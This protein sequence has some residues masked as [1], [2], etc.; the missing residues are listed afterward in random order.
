MTYWN[1]KLLVRGIGVKRII[2]KKILC[3]ILF[4]ILSFSCKA[5]NKVSNTESKFINENNEEISIESLID[6]KDWES[7]KKIIE[8]G[9]TN[10]YIY[11]TVPLLSYFVSNNLT[12]M[13]KLLISRGVDIQKID[14]QL[15]V[16]MFETVI[17][18][19]NTELERLFLQNGIDLNYRND[20]KGNASYLDMLLAINDYNL[21][22]EMVDIF[23]SFEYVREYLH[24]DDDTLFSIIWRWSDLSESYIE[25][26][27]G[28][29]FKVS[30]DLPV[31]HW[32]IQNLDALKFFISKGADTRKVFYGE[33][34]WGSAIDY[35]DFVKKS[36]NKQQVDRSDIDISL[37]ENMDNIIVFLENN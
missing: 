26:I 7:L 34:Y 24:K 37:V 35:A 36:L 23:L 15:A 10:N 21:Q 6:N 29:D 14:K 11:K 9:S 33:D 25:N 17:Y 4:S 30:N 2:T 27:Y 3:F 22:K 32:A 20:K 12:D 1:L 5:K 31:L 28:K 13:A 19:K 16:P 18:N 8:K